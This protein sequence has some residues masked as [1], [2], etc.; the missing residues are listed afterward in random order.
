MSSFAETAIERLRL[1]P[2]RVEPSPE[3]YFSLFERLEDEAAR[4]REETRQRAHARAWELAKQ[5][6]VVPIRDI[7]ELHG[8][9][10]PEDESIDDF[11]VWLRATRR[12]D[13]DRSIPE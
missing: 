12:E 9:F 1:E 8:N 11:L 7:K 2:L 10:W 5:Q 3:M 13:K 6:G 4:T